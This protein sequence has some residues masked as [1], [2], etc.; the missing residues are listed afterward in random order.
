MPANEKEIKVRITAKDDAS[1]E[2]ESAMDKVKTAAKV[3]FT[4]VAGA[5]ALS[6]NAAANF[7]K[8][9][10]N[11]YTLVDR[12]KEAFRDMENDIKVMARNVPVSIDDLTA[13]LYDVR[14]AGIDAGAAMGVLQNSAKLGV[15]GLGTTKEAVNLATSA[16][17]AFSLKGREADAMFNTMFLT[18]KA[19]KTTIAELAQSFGNVAPVAAAAGIKLEE[20]Q[21]ATAALTVTG[22]K[23]SVA[24]T[25][26]RAAILAIQAPSDAMQ[27]ILQKAGITDVEATLKKEGLVKVMGKIKT[28]ADGNTTA[29]KNA[30]G[31]VEALGASLSLAGP[32][33]ELFNTVLQ[34]MQ[35]S[36]KSTE[37]PMKDLNEAFEIQKATFSAQAQLIKN[38]LNTVLID[39]G[40]V[41][42]PILIEKMKV[43]SE[44]ITK[45]TDWWMGLSA[46]TKAF[47]GTVAGAIGSFVATAATLVG[48]A[49]AVVKVKEA[50]AALN[51]VMKANPILFVVGL[52]IALGVALYNLYQNNEEFRKK[53]DEI[54]GKVKGTVSGAIKAIS[55]AFTWFKETIVPVFVGAWEWL[56]EKAGA[57]IKWLQEK[58][59]AFND[60]MKPLWDALWRFYKEV[61]DPILKWLGQA[62]SDVFG[63]L[64]E[65]FTAM[66]GVLKP[67]WGAL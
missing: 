55:D 6:V 12:N 14:S 25:Q 50:M 18:V 19:G 63:V 62:I 33:G 66:A 24:Q 60:W 40:S 2:L 13:A 26:L 56:S 42:M 37:G 58:Y 31:S 29:L 45:L 65:K 43:V 34:G 53:V 46:E 10:T 27:K 47:V 48:I 59:Q 11:V 67:I 52:L 5:V 57:A 4:A 16:I 30:Y 21:A 64:K 1:R 20:L 28:A 54:W 51:L 44:T 35:E 23:A 38:Q 3:A 49:T 8:G 9:M 22:Q 7:E 39:L 41:I 36:L 17:N 15:A 32:Q 61:V